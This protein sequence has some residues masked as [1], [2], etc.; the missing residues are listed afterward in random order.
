VSTDNFVRFHKVIPTRKQIKLILEDYLNELGDISYD[1][2][3]FYAVI[4][5]RPKNPF[6]KLAKLSP[7]PYSERWFEVY[8]GSLKDE[9]PS[10]DVITRQADELTY[11]IAL[12]F[13]KLLARYFQAK[14]DEA[15]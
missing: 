4:P 14:L 12:G 3:T 7:H 13:A 11:N 10:I 2:T 6:E 15:S 8:I 1:K 5:G 9:Q